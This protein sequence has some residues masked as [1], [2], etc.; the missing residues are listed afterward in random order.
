MMQTNICKN[1]ANTETMN[2]TKVQIYL[3]LLITRVCYGTVF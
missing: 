3:H 1:I 2:T